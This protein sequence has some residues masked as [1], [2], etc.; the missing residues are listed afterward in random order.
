MRSIG[1]IKGGSLENA[2]VLD[3]E[4]ILNE[5]GFRMENECVKHKVLDCIGDMFTSGYHMLA[6]ITADKTGHYHNNEVLKKLFAN[7]E[8]YE[9]IE[10]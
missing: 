2:V 3:G 7:K 10:E 6:E 1:L 5:G 9:I 4:N 8:N